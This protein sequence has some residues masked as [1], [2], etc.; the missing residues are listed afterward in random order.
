[1]E[2]FVTLF[3]CLFLPQGLALQ[4]SMER[5]VRDYVLWILCVDDEAH[6]V[7]ARLDLPN[8]RLLK[9]SELETAEL[10][11]VKPSRSI[12]GIAGL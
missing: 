12:A 2:H 7:L 6:D 4:L 3:N 11:S 10:L 8:V 5:H 1:M 9:L